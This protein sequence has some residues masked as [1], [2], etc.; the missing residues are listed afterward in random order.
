MQYDRE[1]AWDAL[2]ALLALLVLFLAF[3]V[4]WS[5]G[6]EEITKKQKRL[7]KPQHQ[8]L[9][10]P[11]PR[12]WV[13]R[14]GKA[15]DLHPPDCVMFEADGDLEELDEGAWYYLPLDLVFEPET[16]RPSFNGQQYVCLDRDDTTKETIARRVYI[17]E[18]T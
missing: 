12:P 7:V 1:I 5:A 15:P 8:R 9:M 17:R 3:A 16:V 18:L 11:R 2:S 4:V 6:A 10:L 14:W 13:E